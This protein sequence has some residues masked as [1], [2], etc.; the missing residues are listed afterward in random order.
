GI[1]RGAPGALH[2]ELLPEREAGLEVTRGAS[3]LAGLTLGAGGPSGLRRSPGSRRRRDRHRQDEGRQDE[4][5]EK[6]EPETRRRHEDLL[7]RRQSSVRFDHAQEGPI[8]LGARGRLGAAGSGEGFEAFGIRE[9]DLAA[10][11]LD[12]ALALELREGERDR[13]ARG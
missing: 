5:R 9:D 10:L 6:H 1:A 13:L 4:G 2:E 7:A 12:Q 11:G 3:L 8:T